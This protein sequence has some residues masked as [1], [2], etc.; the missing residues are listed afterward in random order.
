MIAVQ[1]GPSGR[2]FFL[3]SMC[4]IMLAGCAG[5]GRQ[6]DPPRVKLAN[7]VVKDVKFLETAFEVQLRVFNTNDSP[8]EIKGLECDIDLNGEPFAI[9]VSKV[10]T[11][12]PSYDTAIIP[13]LVYSS[14]VA[15]VKSVHGLQKNEQLQYRLKGKLRLGENTYPATLPFES[16]GTF[17]FKNIMENK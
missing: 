2:P 6:L 5:L 4:L 13:I 7:I 16:E 14:V 12:I 17:S 11:K 9:G 15:M 8:L 1:P 3:L 10:D